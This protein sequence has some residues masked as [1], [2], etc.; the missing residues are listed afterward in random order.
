[1]RVRIV[2]PMEVRMAHVTME[3]DTITEAPEAFDTKQESVPP[4]TKSRTQWR[5]VSAVLGMAILLVLAGRGFVDLL[6]RWA[7]PFEQKVIDRTPA[8]LLVAL[9]DL[10]EYHAA[11]GTFQV[12][13]DLEHDTPYVPSLISGERVTFLAVG[14]VD[15]VV[16]FSS[17]DANRVNVSADRKSVEITL[18]APKLAEA[19]LDNTESRIVDRDRGLVQRLSAVFQDNP[20]SE[21]E[22]YR[23]AETKL[24][25]AATESDLTKRAEENTR[26]MLTG[27]A[28]SLG[29]TDVTVTFASV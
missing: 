28:R 14:S 19:Q 21:Q 26:E 22:L 29:F 25:A 16:D 20:T 27:L 18:P 13:V 6:P 7:N 10:A 8:A 23:V 4:E 24:A 11:T 9:E 15:A 1:M 2:A 12:L 17:F 5:L 3:R